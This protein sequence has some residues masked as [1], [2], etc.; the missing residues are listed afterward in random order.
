MSIA[1]F[2]DF[3][4]CTKDLFNDDFDTKSSLKIKSE[5]PSG[6]VLTSTTDFNCNAPFTSKVSAKWAHEGYAVDK[7]EISSRDKV[8]LETS[9]A[10]LVPGLTLEFK[11]ATGSGATAS[12]GAVY[13]HQFATI[14]SDLDILAFSTANASVLGGSA[15]FLAGASANFGLNKFEVKD[16]TAAISYSPSCGLYAGV[17]ANKKFSEFNALLQY[18]VQPKLRVAA[19]L[20]CVPKTSSHTCSVAVAY[21][22]CENTAVKV[23]ANCDGVITASVK[24]TMPKKFTVV[25]AAELD[26]RNTSN[27]NFGVAATLG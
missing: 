18:K 22:C 14:T 23:K 27:I 10:K 8:K 9:L 6:V 4:K 13:K 5:A 7:L 12:L 15:G 26:T 2:K 17:V 19:L 21:D 1:I 11:G 24:H 3:A 25:G 20:D 16:Y